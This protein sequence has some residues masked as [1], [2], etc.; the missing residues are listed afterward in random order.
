MRAVRAGRKILLLYVGYGD[1]KIRA[2]GRRRT[3]KRR[4]VT[5]VLLAPTRSCRGIIPH[6]HHHFCWAKRAIVVCCE[7]HS[8]I[9]TPIIYPT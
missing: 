3:G 6:H 8:K 1:S 5:E 2:P 4:T 7:A 9:T